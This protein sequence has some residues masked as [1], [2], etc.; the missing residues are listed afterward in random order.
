MDDF[1]VKQ[2]LLFEILDIVFQYYSEGTQDC[3]LIYKTVENL[4]VSSL[5]WVRNLNWGQWIMGK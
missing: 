3:T 4:Q 1:I 5:G 2:W